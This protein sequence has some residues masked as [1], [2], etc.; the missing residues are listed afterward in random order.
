MPIVFSAALG[1]APGIV[2]W[3]QA[4]DPAQRDALYAGFERLRLAFEA[5][6]VEELVLLTSEHWTN[7][8]L[9]H[10]SPFCIGRGDAFKGPVEPW[11]GLQPST[12]K[13]CPDLAGRLVETFHDNDIDVG[14]AY[15]LALDHGSMVPLHFLTPGM[16]VPI[17]PVF[18]NTLAAP[19]PSPRR[20]A[21]LG[22]V[23]GDVLARSPRRIGVIATGG[24]SHDPGE[25]N[26]GL[27]DE[28]FDRR[29]LEQMTSG[30]LERLAAYQVSDFMAAGAGAVELLSW[31]ALA[32]TLQ[33]F[34]GEVIAYEAVRPWAT[35]IGLMLLHANQ[36]LPNH[37]ES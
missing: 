8:F 6:G 37:E 18:I 9:D 15:E 10:I 3:Q 20:C 11:L 14:F 33:H 4:A 7:F 13:G 30:N 36:V 31:V 29:F 19:Q 22:R 28:A 5:A 1:H 23:L 16:D 17:V 21:A 24:M 34:H 27:I 26:H 25:R 2:A 12:I 35:G 32:G